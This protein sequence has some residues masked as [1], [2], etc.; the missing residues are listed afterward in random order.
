M[1]EFYEVK[2][3]LRKERENNGLPPIL[4]ND[5]V[6]RFYFG[7]CTQGTLNKYVKADAKLDACRVNIADSELFWVKS[8][9]DKYFKNKLK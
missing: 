1:K 8:E 4:N 3:E 7:G 6:R 5:Q 2:E 9:L